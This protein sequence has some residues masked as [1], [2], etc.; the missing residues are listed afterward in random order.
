MLPF[1]DVR[2]VEYYA[3]HD[4]DQARLY[5]RSSIRRELKLL[6]AQRR[7]EPQAAAVTYHSD[8]EAAPV[9]Q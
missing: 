8:M 2:H 5:R 6:R 7:S 4:L 3:G 1:N 9:A